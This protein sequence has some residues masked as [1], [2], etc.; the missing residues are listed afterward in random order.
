M[1]EEEIKETPPRGGQPPQKGI[2]ALIT[3]V[4]SIP[5]DVLT[6]KEGSLFLKV[7]YRQEARKVVEIESL[8][9]DSSKQI[10]ELEK[11]NIRLEDAL[12]T[13]HFL[14]LISSVLI[15]IAII[16]IEKAIERQDIFLSICA[17]ILIIVSF[18]MM[19]RYISPTN[20]N[21][22]EVK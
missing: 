19:W 4:E 16:L 1:P 10:T 18:A 3:P 20:Q 12:K 21:Q 15:G 2:E 14:D 13:K 5:D 9:R 7:L 6:S 8:L 17:I 22:E 11:T